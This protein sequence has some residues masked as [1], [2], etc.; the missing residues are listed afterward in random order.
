MSDSYKLMYRQALLELGEVLD[1]V[2]EL[3]LDQA[4]EAIATARTVV[5]FGG[6]REGLQI[7]GFAMR[8][9][10]LGRSVAVVGD[11]TTP[12]VQAGDVFL[13]TVGP[14]EIST[15]VALVGVAKAAGAK[16]LVIT[17]QPE[18]RVP[19]MADQVL[20]LPAQTMANDQGPSTSLLPMGSVYEGALFVLFEVMILKLKDTLS[21][22]SEEMRGNHTNLE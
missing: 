2:S 3:S 5:V 7:R 16:V 15:A 18:G 9:F 13:V 6:G 20:I 22:S 8:L 10:H 12:A 21:V 4:V 17:A 1:R 19:K 14:G 11:M